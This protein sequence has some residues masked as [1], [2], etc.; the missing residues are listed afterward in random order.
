MIDDLKADSARWDNERRAQT[1]RNSTPGGIF[2]SREAVSLPPRLLSNSPVGQYRA[3]ETHQFR[4]QSGPTADGPYQSDPYGRDAPSFDSPRYPGTGS[5]GYSG[6]SVPYQSQP[7]HQPYSSSNPYGYQHSQQSPQTAQDP[8]YA[9]YS[10]GPPMDQRYATSQAPSPYVAQG[11]N[12]QNRRYPDDSYASSMMPSS[13]AANQAPIYA[14]SGP[15]PSGY[16][17]T[18]SPYQQQYTNPV[19]SAATAGYQSLYP[20]EG[21]YG[22]GQT[23]QQ[24]QQQGFPPQAQQYENPTS[25]T[26]VPPTTA[27]STAGANKR[28]SERDD[29]RH[30][31]HPRR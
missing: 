3:S 17:A 29:D 5:H 30:Q 19:P 2:G 14:S 28:R 10:Q 31:R 22:R 24:Q 27:T 7:Q 6:A 12:Q 9:G 25:R 20:T 26:S 8:R 11:T 16:P 13:V 1:S 4:Q 18:S 23:P 15:S 21:G